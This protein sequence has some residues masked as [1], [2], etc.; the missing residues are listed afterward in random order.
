MYSLDP[1]PYL[2]KKSL[3]IIF[4]LSWIYLSPSIFIFMEVFYQDLFLLVW[5]IYLLL[6]TSAKEVSFDHLRVI[7]LF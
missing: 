4:V 3:L 2:N 5:N 6:I 1:M 7:L